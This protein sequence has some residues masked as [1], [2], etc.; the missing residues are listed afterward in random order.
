MDKQ[1][2]LKQAMEMTQAI[3][4]GQEGFVLLKKL[5]NME[6]KL[7]KPDIQK[8]EIVGAEI[9]TIKGQ[10]G[11]TGA[12]GEKGEKGV[13]GKQG[14]QG[15]KGETGEKGDKGDD[16]ITPDTDKIAS[17]ASNQAYN[18]LLPTI[19]TIDQIVEKL[20]EQGEAVRDSLE[21]L[22]GEDRLDASAIQGLPELKNEVKLGGYGGLNLYVNNAKKGATKTINFVGT[23]VSFSKVNGRETLTFTSDSENLWDRTGTI[24]DTH[25]ANDTVRIG[26]G[27]LITPKIH[28]SADSTTAVGIFKADGVTNVLNVDT[29]NAMVGIGTTAPA[30]LIHS[31]SAAATN[32]ILT[33]DTTDAAATNLTYIDLQRAGV[34]KA[35]LGFGS[36]S[37]LSMWNREANAIRFGT[38]NL[39]KARIDKDG[40]VGIGTT[41][42]TTTNG[43]LDISSGGISQVIGA[44][45]NASTRTNATA[46]YG[47]LGG[48]HYTNAQA[49][50]TL[51][52]HQSTGAPA[53][54]V[55]IG[56][57]F[58]AGTA[59]TIL[60]F[61]TAANTTT[62]A[63]TERMR[64]DN[65]GNVG[66]GTTGPLAKLDIQGSSDGDQMISIGSNTVSGIL[67]TPANFYFNADS[68]NS[69]SNGW[70]V[71]GFNRTGFSG[72]AEAMRI[73]EN[74]N[75]GIG[76]TTPSTKLHVLKTTEQL[77]LGYD[78]SN[79]KSETV[80]ST[81]SVTTAL[82]GTSPINIFSQAV[83]F[84][85]GTQSSD[86]SAGATG[87][88]TTVDSKTVTVKNGL[89][90]SIV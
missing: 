20:P 83:K 52:G 26:T 18:R 82:T 87:S 22:T 41:A 13:Q 71:F 17:E 29:T 28:P 9:V 88:F 79:Y 1:S 57:G 86:G 45:F 64:I 44:D 80:G 35:F 40:N 37:T 12:K 30:T 90:T 65:D 25:T 2:K 70:M 49:P 58:A 59:A 43:G 69:A 89:I 24:L 3:K 76:T 50:V 19:P 75:V 61:Y 8:T 72:G 73:L 7:E 39:E 5:D 4:A 46:K 53:N 15:V 54:I 32:N 84:S 48:Y 11:D 78:V 16:G 81:G 51:I 77:R 68:D 33:L 67:N 14:I 42:P 38:S 62:A 74:G 31:K 6:S 60:Q 56:G 23:D 85:G 34:S 27:G 55:T 66:I 63:G 36:T 21:M 10:K 47:F